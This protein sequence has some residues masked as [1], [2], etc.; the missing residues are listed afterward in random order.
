MF[1][2]RVAETH[3]TPTPP[4]TALRTHKER[5]TCEAVTSLEVLLTLTYAMLCS[6]GCRDELEEVLKLAKPQHFL[7]VHG[8]Y[9]FLCAHAQLAREVR[10]KPPTHSVLFL[11]A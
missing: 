5:C 10:T 1:N 2:T 9:A 6:L 3:L 8:E 4:A 7:P 11:L